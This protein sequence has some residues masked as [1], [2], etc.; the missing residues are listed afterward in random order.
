MNSTKPSVGPSWNNA[1]ATITLPDWMDSVIKGRTHFATPA[2]QM[3]LV[4]DLARANVQNNTGGP[5]GAAVFDMSDGRLLAPGVNRVVPLNCS[6]LHAEA[7][8]IALAQMGV[9]LFS[10][11]SGDVKARLVTSAQP[12]VQCWGI[13]HWAGITELLYG[14]RATDTEKIGFN[15]GPIP[16]DWVQ[17][18]SGV[19]VTG[20]F[21]RDT[22]VEVFELYTRSGGRIYN[23]R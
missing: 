6:I 13:T 20:D 10:F 9:G 14:A 15:E 16:T 8:A 12:C 23:A 7:I 18:L 19:Q 11:A 3:Q 5:F 1:A 2:E 17:R 22:A 21:M 4:I